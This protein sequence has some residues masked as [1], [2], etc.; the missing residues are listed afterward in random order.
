MTLLMDKNPQLKDGT[1]DK[2]MHKKYRDSRV[3]I[4]G[5][6]EVK[7]KALM[8]EWRRCTKEYKY[9]QLEYVITEALP[10]LLVG[11]ALASGRSVVEPAGIGSVG[12]RGSF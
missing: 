3:L 7:A 1:E 6:E 4:K 12:H 10:P 5:P 2:I 8:G 9:I 11:L